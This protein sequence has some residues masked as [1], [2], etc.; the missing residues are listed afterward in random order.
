[1]LHYI[2]GDKVGY[3]IRSL[4][5]LINR[6]VFFRQYM[7]ANSYCGVVKFKFKTP[8]AV[9]RTIYK[10]KNYEPEITR[11]VLN[12]IKYNSDDIIIDVGANIGWYSLL[13]DHM[14][15]GPG[16]IYAFEPN[17]L[18]YSLLKYNISLNGASKIVA[19]NK[20]VSDRNGKATLYN[21]GDNNLG[22]HSMLPLFKGSSE[23]I[24]TITLDKFI[25]KNNDKKIIKLIKIDV[26]GYEL[27]VLL[28]AKNVLE[29]T[30][31]LIVEFSPDI[32]LQNKIAPRSVIQLLYTNGFKPY[33]F[34]KDK[35]TPLNKKDF[36]KIHKTTTFLW[37]KD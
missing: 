32:M 14:E 6:F 15:Y 20:A 28:G 37:K 2:K 31:N 17:S 16:V 21:Y 7:V 19:V 23:K 24:T 4:V 30:E 11:F 35:I 3:V 5:Y 13:L 29:Y 27:P 1:M 36:L 8:D 9:G 33:S 22:R 26:E 25:K 12:E 10:Y 18:N 34:K